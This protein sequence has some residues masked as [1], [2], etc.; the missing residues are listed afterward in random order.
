MPAP[1]PWIRRAHG[2]VALLVGAAWVAA[3]LFPTTVYGEWFGDLY[4]G[5]AFT[6]RHEVTLQSPAGDQQL[7]DIGF[8]GPRCSAAGAGTG[9]TTSE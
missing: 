5:A 4:L 9:S 6:Q 8:I 1:S 7:A 2:R 3:L